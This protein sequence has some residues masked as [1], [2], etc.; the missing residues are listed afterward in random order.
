MIFLIWGGNGWIGGMLCE[1]LRNQ[2]HEVTIAKSRT[3]DYIG[4]GKELDAVKPDRVL[5]VA[6]ITGKPSVDY[7]EDH[8]EDTFLANAVGTFNVAD[9]CWRRGIH[10]TYYATGCIYT[11]DDQHSIFSELDPPNFRGSTYSKSKILAE[12][13]LAPYSN[14]LTLRIRMPISQDLHPKNII[15]KLSQYTKVINIPNSFTVLP[16]MLPISIRM[17]QDKLSG[18][19]NFTNPGAITHNDI[20]KLYQQYLNPNHT[21]TNFTEEE[22]NVILKSK[23]SN[24]TLDT[25]KLEAYHPITP[26]QLAIEHVFATIASSK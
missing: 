19:Y 8:Q 12:E 6:G 25:T 4:I 24:C 22:Q 2:G 15:T 1:L 20:L 21:W 9:A 14:V 16:E 26:I 3:Q 13:L 23:R 11:Y 18:I 17:S 5:N 10:V 7:C